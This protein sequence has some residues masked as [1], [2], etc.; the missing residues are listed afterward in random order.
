LARLR[1]QVMPIRTAYR[2]SR[3]TEKL[4]VEYLQIE[5]QRAKLVQKYGESQEGQM[6][7]GKQMQRE[8]RVKQENLADFAQDFGE[9]LKEEVEVDFEPLDFESLPETIQ[10]SAQDLAL[11]DFIFVNKEEHGGGK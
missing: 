1:S 5:E 9:L 11:I 7:Q 8:L 3:I 2:V 6:P 10:M 4:R